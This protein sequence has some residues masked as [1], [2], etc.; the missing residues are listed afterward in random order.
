MLPIPALFT[1]G[2]ISGA[3]AS[4]VLTPIELIKCQ[5]QVQ[6]LYSTPETAKHNGI[7]YLVKEVVKKEG[8][9]GFWKG[10]TGTFLRE[11]GG[12]A[13]WFGA[14]EYVSLFFRNY[15]KRETNTI[16]ELLI[17]GACGGIAYNASLFPADTIKSK[18][19]TDSIISGSSK[20]Q[21]FLEVGKEIYTANGIKGFYRGMGI[22]LLRAAPA[23]ATIFLVY[24]KL[25]EFGNNYINPNI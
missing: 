6:R 11:S 10:Q 9:K 15:H 14:Y 18:M 8:L 3:F 12:S 24:E 17:S 7:I 19:Q 4:F 1:A 25:K 22:T 21:G 13:S 20:S 2:A 5:M 16:G 23:S